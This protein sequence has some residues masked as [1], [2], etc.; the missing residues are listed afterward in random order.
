M[1]T[2]PTS[3]FVLDASVTAAWLLPGESSGPARMV[4]TR[5][6]SDGALVPQLWHLEI[7]NV[8]LQAERRNRINAGEA[9]QHLSFLNTL[10]IQTDSRPDLVTTYRL[11]QAYSLSFYDAV[12]LELAARNH[13]DVATLDA[14]MA[15]AAT[16]E[17][18]A[19]VG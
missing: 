18:L 3:A 6:L 4:L 19:L 2:T 14:K 7:R 16:A 10:P 12:Y 17:G 15:A 1:L 8:L 11:A 9:Q 5:M 13:L